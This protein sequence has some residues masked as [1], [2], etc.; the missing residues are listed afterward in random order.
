VSFVTVRAIFIYRGS[1]AVKHA[2]REEIEGQI[3]RCRE[4][5]IEIAH[6]DS[7]SHAHEEWAVASAV[8]Q[9]AREAKIP[10]VRVCRTFGGGV[11]PV[12]CLYRRVVN[13]RIRAAGLATT[14]YFGA[15]DD[16]LRFCQKYG[17]P[18][19]MNVSWEIMVHPVRVGGQL[20]DGWLHRPLEDVLRALPMGKHGLPG[21]QR[22]KE[23]VS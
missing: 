17:P 7:H 16:Y 3:A 22:Q 23:A 15:P 10:R 5:G 18:E 21:A 13:L 8:I 19:G 11:S 14:D 2:V 6:L 12:K 4:R 1:A 9:A 20:F